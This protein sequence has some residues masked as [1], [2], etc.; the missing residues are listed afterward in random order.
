MDKWNSIR[1]SIAQKKITGH[2]IET[3]F[4]NMRN[5]HLN[6]EK[7]AKKELDMIDLPNDVQQFRIKQTLNA[8]KALSRNRSSDAVK[9]QLKKQI[10]EIN[11]QIPEEMRV[12][13]RANGNCKL[14]TEN[15][16]SITAIT[17]PS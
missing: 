14:S 11:E 6:K 17:R 8:D 10:D 1:A 3:S 13:Y 16:R 15:R 9:T 4:G 12:K 7:L 2:L 5:I